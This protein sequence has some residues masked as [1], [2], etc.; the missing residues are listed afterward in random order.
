MDGRKQPIR[1]LWE[2]NGKF[3]ARMAVENADGISRTRWVALDGAQ[4]V[5]QA[6]ERLKALHVDR[7]RNALPVLKRTPKFADYAATYF[8]YYDDVKAKKRPATI[9]K[10]RGAIRLW[11][12]HIGGLRLDKI[13][14]LHINSFIQKRQAAGM[15]GLYRQSG[16]YRASQRP[17][18][19][20]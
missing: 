8:A 14:R 16:H 11:T 5:P 18:K 7:T 20:H 4:T 13:K 1:G 3:I 6:L 19:S 2:R 9:Q 17:E 10:E 12:E 15:S